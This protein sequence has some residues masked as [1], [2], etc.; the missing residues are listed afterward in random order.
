MN[1]RPQPVSLL[2]RAYLPIK[3][4][5]EKNCLKSHPVHHHLG[6]ILG[7]DRLEQEME[8]STYTVPTMLEC[9]KQKYGTPLLP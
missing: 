5:K 1:S 6:V 7:S 8:V 4:L 2:K 3:E 9:N